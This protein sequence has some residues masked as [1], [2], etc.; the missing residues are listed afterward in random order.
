MN[1]LGI[2]GLKDG[3]D[4]SCV[5]GDSRSTS[6]VVNQRSVH[7][8][9][10]SRAE[11][12]LWVRDELRE[13]ITEIKP[14]HVAFRVAEAGQSISKSIIERAE[15]E[16]VLQTVVADLA[17]PMTRLY[18]D[19][20][21]MRRRRAEVRP[22]TTTAGTRRAAVRRGIPANVAITCQ[23]RPETAHSWWRCAAKGA[24]ST[25]ALASIVRTGR[26]IVWPQPKPSA[27]AVADGCTRRRASD[28]SF[29]L[30]DY[31]LEVS[32]RE[33]E[34]EKGRRS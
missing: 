19:C 21:G 13:V 18:A 34:K 4:W 30:D 8:P 32:S 6:S 22:G 1:I 16:G 10:G 2:K 3:F 27:G 7:A 24:A 15:V 11:T 17:I 20:R 12:L 23:G 9:V 5:I 28:L 29:S 33:G 26:D 14:D 25:H 31:K